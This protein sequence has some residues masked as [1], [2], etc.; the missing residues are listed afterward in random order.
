MLQYTNE[1]RRN[2]HTVDDNVLAVQAVSV[3]HGV[4]HNM[5]L[6]RATTCCTPMR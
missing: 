3:A 2:G 5:G 4:A 6:N 1:T